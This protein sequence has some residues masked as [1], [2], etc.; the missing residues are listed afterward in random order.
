M[1]L[2]FRSC[3]TSIPRKR[4]KPQTNNRSRGERFS[5]LIR[6]P[7]VG[8]S[9]GKQLNGQVSVGSFQRLVGKSVDPS[10]KVQFGRHWKISHLSKGWFEYRLDD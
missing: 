3:R 10:I 7:L 4:R 1:N 6:S 5:K 9:L 2:N 8:H